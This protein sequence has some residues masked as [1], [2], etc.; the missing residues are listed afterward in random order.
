M[1]LM[2][3]LLS[4]QIIG[5]MAYTLTINAL[6]TFISDNETYWQS[7]SDFIPINSSHDDYYGHI[8]LWEHM[9]MSFDLEFHGRTSNASS[10]QWEQMFRL[11]WPALT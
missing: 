2:R 8:R 5:L 1:R 9:S 11:G 3:T 10:E 6:N 4:Y 7:T